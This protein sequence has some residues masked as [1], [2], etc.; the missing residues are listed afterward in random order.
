M[1]SS[2]FFAALFLVT[3]NAQAV[4]YPGPTKS[5]VFYCKTEG[6]QTKIYRQ[7]NGAAQII[8]ES[9]HQESAPQLLMTENVTELRNKSHTIY[10]SD[11]VVLKITNHPSG[12]MPGTLFVDTANDVEKVDMSCQ[13]V[14]TILD[15]KPTL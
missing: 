1:K 15:A 13:I 10:T 3:V 6:L 8:V 2:M 11:D 7:A 9:V 5:Q 12:H 14:Y 4:F